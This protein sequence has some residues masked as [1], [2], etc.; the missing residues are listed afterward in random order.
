MR[1]LVV[2]A[3]CEVTIEESWAIDVPDDFD[4]EAEDSMDL[5]DAAMAG[6]SLHEISERSMEDEHDREVLRWEWAEVEAVQP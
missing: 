1:R 5:I 6:G 4:P 3:R 2:V